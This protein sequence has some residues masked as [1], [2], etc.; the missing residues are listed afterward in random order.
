MTR[1]KNLAIRWFMGLVLM[2]VAGTARAQLV[3]PDDGFVYSDTSVPRVDI[4]MSGTDLESLYA[5]P[6]SDFE[7]PAQFSMSRGEVTERVTSAGI[8]FRGNTSR[9]KQK[10]SFRISFNTFYPGND[11]HGIEEMNLNAETN[12]PSMVR[13]KLSWHI[14]RYLG[15]PALRENHVLLY[16]NNAFYGVYNNTEHVDENFVKSRFGTNDGNLYKCLWPADLAYRGEDQDEYKFEQEDRR[17]YDLRINEEWDDY[18][19]LADLVGVIHNNSGEAFREEV[20]LVMNVQQYLKIAAADVMTANWDGYIGNKNNYYLY[21]DQ[22]TGRMEYIP[23]DLDNTWGLDWLGVDWTSRSIYHWA[24][25]SMP[26]YDKIMQLQGYRDQLSMYVKKLATYMTS[27]DMVSEVERW[28]GQISPW[29]SQDPYYSLDFGYTYNDFLNAL[30]SGIQ[31]DWWLPHGVLE[32]ADLRAASALAECGDVDPLPCFSHVRVRNSGGMILADWSVE[33]NMEFSTTMHYRLGGGEWQTLIQAGPSVT[34]PVSGIM[35]FRDSVTLPGGEV[36]WEVYFTATDRWDTPSRFPA[37]VIAGTSPWEPG[38]LLINEFM[39]SNSSCCQDEYEE[40]DDWVEISN[41][42]PSL[43]WTGDF[44]LSDD[45]KK[46]GRYRFPQ[47]YIYPFDYMLVWLD[48]QPEQGDLHT[49]FKIDM[50][51]EQLILSGRPADGFPVMDSLSFGMQVTDVAMGRTAD[52]GDSWALLTRV[53][54]GYSNLSSGMDLY[55]AERGLTLYPNPV[56]GGMLY[57]SKQVSGK[58][59]DATGRTVRHVVDAAFADLSGLGS[60][61]YIFIPEGYNP[62]KFVILGN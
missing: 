4:T 33:D 47:R 17:A 57:F 48:G 25:E 8:R 53:T 7:Y 38:P 11:F 36:D 45:A 26:L 35:T 43:V 1:E 60:G 5:D 21:R 19:D 12:D 20:E 22:V 41:P 16:I 37:G 39:A 52:G 40:F 28:R 29:V 10:K 2:L 9:D 18:R 34:D 27:D 59:L 51:G 56:T 46:P 42:T 30:T 58:I 44:Y 13:S 32:Y 23:Y 62:R 6:S 50:E 49:P 31:E 3:F 15:L 14:F 24:R 55:M 61:T 54:P